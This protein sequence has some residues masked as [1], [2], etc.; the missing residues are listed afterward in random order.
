MFGMYDH[1]TALDLSYWNITKVTATKIPSNLAAGD[2]AIVT[3]V[4][5]TMNQNHKV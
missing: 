3:R 2:I 4:G 1:A 5:S